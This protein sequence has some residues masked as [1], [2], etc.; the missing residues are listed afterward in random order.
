MRGVIIV[1]AHML[2]LQQYSGAL[3]AVFLWAI[4]LVHS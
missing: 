1:A 2:D 3:Q 4:A